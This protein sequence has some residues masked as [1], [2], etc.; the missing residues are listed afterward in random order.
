MY[1]LWSHARESRVVGVLLW[2]A[3]LLCIVIILLVIIIIIIIV[4]I[5]FVIMTMII[6]RFGTKCSG[7]GQGISPQDLVRKARDK[8]LITIIISMI[9]I[10]IS[11]MIIILSKMTIISMIVMI[12]MMTV[13]NMMI[14]IMRTVM[15][16]VIK[17]I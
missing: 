7:C 14:E 15:I 2:H 16:V 13:K 10:I 1:W 17:I 11:M 6:R 12:S 5:Q 4:I 8:V 3:S 9:I